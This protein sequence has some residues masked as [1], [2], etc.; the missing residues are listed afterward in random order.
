MDRYRAEVERR[1]NR[2]MELGCGAKLFVRGQA[3]PLEAVCT[4]LSV[5]GLAVHAG[6]VPRADEVLE[7]LVAAPRGG[8][9][10]PPL[11]VRAVVRRCQRL[12]SGDYE[13]GLE[14]VDVLE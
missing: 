14:I 2:R 3:E 5:G 8:V 13:I 9:A 4:E 7:V 12:S 6:Y 1:R 10:R 11:R